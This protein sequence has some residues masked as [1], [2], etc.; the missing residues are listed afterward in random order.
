MAEEFRPQNLKATERYLE[1]LGPEKVP[2]EEKFDGSL[3]KNSAMVSKLKSVTED[4]SAKLYED[5]SKL[6]FQKFVQEI[7]VSLS[8]AAGKI[9]SSGDLVGF[10]KICSLL[11]CRSQE[12]ISPFLNALLKNLL[13]YTPS[14]SQSSATASE[15]TLDKLEQ[16]KQLLQKTIL[17]VLGEMTLWGLCE[18]SLFVGKSSV[19]PCSMPSMSVK[20]VGD[21]TLKDVLS[22]EGGFLCYILFLYLKNDKDKNNSYL[23]LHFA[24]HFGTSFIASTTVLS[25]KVLSLLQTLFEE[26]HKYTCEMLIDEMKKF[27]KMKR[28]N[29]DY[30]I[31]RGEL[32]EAQKTRFED[33]KA[34]VDKLTTIAQGLSSSLGYTMPDLPSDVDLEEEKASATIIGNLQNQD[35]DFS[36]SPFGDQETKEFYTDI[37]DIGNLV[38]KVIL[39]L[40]EKKK[41]KKKR[42][43]Q[44]QDDDDYFEDEF[45]DNIDDE[46]LEDIEKQALKNDEIEQSGASA[47]RSKNSVAAGSTSVENIL[48]T[49][50]NLVNKSLIDKA[51][52]DFCNA[53]QHCKEKARASLITTLTQVPRYRH[54]LLPYYTRFIALIHPYMPE[55][56]NTVVAALVSEF[57][58]RYGKQHPMELEHRIKN[59]KFLGELTKFKVCPTHVMFYCFNRLIKPETSGS[60]FTS[61]HVMVA[62]SLLENCGRYMLKTPDVGRKWAPF[63][64]IMKRKCNA[65]YL[66]SHV[67]LMVENAFL[68]ADP[69]DIKEDKKEEKP[70][71]PMEIFVRKLIY[72]DLNP[73][74][75][76]NVLQLLRALPWKNAL[77]QELWDEKAFQERKK[78][79]PEE[80]KEYKP[81]M[82]EVIIPDVVLEIFTKVWK[83]K[84]SDVVLMAEIATGL[85]YFHPDFG[86]KLVDNVLELVRVGLEDMTHFRFQQRRILIVRYLGELFNFGCVSSNIIFEA[87]DSFISFGHQNNMPHPNETP[88]SKF[89]PPTDY[90]RIKLI[91]ELLDTCGAFFNKG[92]HAVKLDKFLVYFQYY[93]LCKDAESMPLEIGFAIDD[94]LERLKPG[95]KR[96]RDFAEAEQM[97]INLKKNERINEPEVQDNHA[98]E[99]DHESVNEESEDDEEN[100]DEQNG[101]VDGDDP[102]EDDDEELLE[103]QEAEI[104]EEVVVVKEKFEEAT[105]EEQMAFSKELQDILSES[106]ASRRNEKRA[107]LDVAIPMSFK[108]TESSKSKAR[109]EI[110]KSDGQVVTFKLMTRGQSVKS[111]AVP[112]DSVIALSAATKKEEKMK[113]Q[114]ALKKITLKMYRNQ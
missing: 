22:L 30:V 70:R 26:Y 102:D 78:S 3:K 2:G 35:S 57:K 76:V 10:M 21:L 42:E 82:A 12:F 72:K 91:T 47:E 73:R 51:V 88:V 77:T 27:N 1:Q 107:V 113:E 32:T 31:T 11:H 69:P 60:K 97:L 67:Q 106:I 62:C 48:L 13:P 65:A 92:S 64:E 79:K 56:G 59:I 84:F 68:A 54:D 94:T 85:T 52:L 23:A 86:V 95:F 74:N 4:N 55:V 28:Y 44:A 45:Y 105:P 63:M 7:T 37:I 5:L 14:K 98:E 43:K 104:E 112:S 9:K 109:N 58:R 83:V 33:C 61:H 101:S 34:T 53:Q 25:E 39:V 15:R 103:E 38:P 99:E 19:F 93:I 50:P 17:R 46:V 81:A 80:N 40:S 71:T 87:L 18:P 110:Q 16:S 6:K 20:F 90:F 96:V 29:E 114:D 111:L 41:K 66:E 8:E 75:V 49:L 24:K 89:D 36:Q 100:D 108:E